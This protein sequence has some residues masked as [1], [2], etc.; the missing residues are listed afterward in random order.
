MGLVLALRRRCL[1]ELVGILA[2]GGIFLLALGMGTVGQASHPTAI[3][4]NHPQLGGWITFVE[5][6]GIGRIAVHIQQPETPRYEDG[7]PVVIN[8]SGF[9]TGS[10]GFDFG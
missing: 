1:V 3:I 7:A 2:I 5:S 8:V 4:D 6:P 10:S 9:F